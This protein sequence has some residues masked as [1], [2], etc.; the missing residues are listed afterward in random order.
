MHKLAERHVGRLSS[1]RNCTSASL[2]L[3]RRPIDPA[4]ARRRASSSLPVQRRSAASSAP[5]DPSSTTDCV[6]HRVLPRLHGHAL[7]ARRPARC[8]TTEHWSWYVEE[9]NPTMRRIVGTPVDLK[10]APPSA[11]RPPHAKRAVAPLRRKLLQCR[12]RSIGSGTSSSSRRRSCITTPS[13][14]RT[15]RPHALSAGRGRAQRS[16]RQDARSSTATRRARRPTSGSITRRS[17]T[18]RSPRP[19]TAARS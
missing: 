7:G 3:D 4:A 5:P 13:K 8:R 14:R 1:R 10:G 6:A 12:R 18:R 16:V 19:P 11:T 9:R 17:C 2:V 15:S